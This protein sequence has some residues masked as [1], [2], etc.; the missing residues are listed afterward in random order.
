VT[1]ETESIRADLVAQRERTPKGDVLALIDRNEVELG[2]LLGPSLTVEAFKT[3]AMTYL[4][5]QPSLWECD[6]YSVV[7]G[8][9]QGAQLGFQL[10][11]P[12]GLFYLVPFKREA[13][14]IVGYRGFVEL[15]YR[16]GQVKDVI[17]ELVY[18]GDPF[19]VTKGT[20]PKI[21]HADAG[22]PGDRP[23]VAAYAVA[24]LRTGGT[25]SK[26]IYE[27]EWEAARQASPA[28]RKRQGPWEDHRPAM[29]RKTALRRLEP[30]LPKTAALGEAF[31][32]DETRQPAMV[33]GDD[34][35][36]EIEAED[37]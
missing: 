28:G 31:T 14:F 24:R 17:A 27:A 11:G 26:V 29:I 22:P 18:E 33:E 7:G 8:L 10:L 30:W 3:A 1:V 19:T 9:R 25:V 4:R 36:S 20:S 34:A 37:A 13:V 35:A 6:P 32:S 2:K 16:S 5:A 12:L 15:A 23:I 21:V